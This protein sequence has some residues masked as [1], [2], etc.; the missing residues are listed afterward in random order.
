M[1]VREFIEQLLKL[2]PEDQFYA[3]SEIDG[4]PYPIAPSPWASDDE[5]IFQEWHGCPDGHGWA[6]R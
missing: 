1:K 3:I 6:L 5:G 4:H 2:D